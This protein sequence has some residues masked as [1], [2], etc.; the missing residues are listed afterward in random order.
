MKIKLIALAVA[1]LVSGVAN[2][3]I[4]DD[5]STSGNGGLLFAAWDGQTSFALN[6]G[7][8]ID[9][10][11]A[12]V[13]SGTGYS[14]TDSAW[15]NWL[16]T[17]NAANVTWTIF[18][19]DQFGAQRGITTTD[20]SNAGVTITNGNARIANVARS[21][22]I[23]EQLN[24]GA[25]AAAG[26]TESI[27]PV[28]SAAYPGNSSLGNGN[29]GYGYNFNSNG[30]LANS[31]YAS[32]LGVISINTPNATTAKSTYASL[33]YNGTAAHA[34]ISSNGTFSIGTV[35]AVPEPET[36]AMLLAGIG[37]IGSI[38]RRRNRAA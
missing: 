15:T 22:F 9:S 33:S 19:N 31:D 38:A 34:W 4:I 24:L 14:F 13:S 20:G 10:L 35:A 8:T 37:M 6:T 21:L 32:G 1:A 12:A 17:A 11:I 36:L 2:A 25:F 29:A 16:S 30:T 5:G 3:N 28:S 23:N 7:L 27:V 26:V 18:A